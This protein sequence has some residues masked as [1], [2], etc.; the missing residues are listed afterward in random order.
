MIGRLP[1]M[2]K[3][4]VFESFVGKQYSDNPRAIYEYLKEHYPEYKLYWS[5]DKRYIKNFSGKDVKIVPRF[6]IRWLFLMALA[7]YWVNNSRM[8]PWTPKPD[9]TYYLYPNLARNLVEKTGS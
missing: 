8:P 2:K 5:A 4:I 6:S 9:H 7:K 1:A 3:T